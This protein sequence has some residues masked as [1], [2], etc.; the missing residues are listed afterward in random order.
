M[1]GTHAA[2]VLAA[3][4]STRLGRAKQ[5][6]TRNGEP[7]VRRAARL[8]LETSPRQLLV[9]VGADREAVTQAL[10]DLP[11]ELVHNAAWRQGLGSSL[12]AAGAHLRRDAEPVV[13]LSCDQPALE[14]EHL[15]ALLEGAQSAASRCAATLH[16]A[17]PGVPAVVPRDWFEHAH[18]DGDC[19]FGRRLRQQPEGAVFGLRAAELELDVDMPGDVER[20][21]QLGWLDAEAAQTVRPDV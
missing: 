11:C 8:A 18:D 1:N 7:L 10:L 4:G 12:R 2:V 20:A 13:V 9:V 14:R 21:V 19:G 6:L 17:L 5:L 3:G 15:L 16:D